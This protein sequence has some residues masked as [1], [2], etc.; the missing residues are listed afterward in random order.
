MFGCLENDYKSVISDNGEKEIESIESVM[1][2]CPTH[3]IIVFNREYDA[4]KIDNKA[5]DDIIFKTLNVLRM[6]NE[7]QDSTEVQADETFDGCS[8]SMAW[9]QV[10]APAFCGN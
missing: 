1:L 8:G 9:N 2:R 10:C 4:V 6:G 3:E 7:G 5:I